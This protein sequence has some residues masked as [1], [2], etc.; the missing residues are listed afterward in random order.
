MAV[1]QLGNFDS[2]DNF[3]FNFANGPFWIRYL[4]YQTVKHLFNKGFIYFGKQIGSFRIL[5]I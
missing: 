3:F 2:T 4:N 1:A 5:Y